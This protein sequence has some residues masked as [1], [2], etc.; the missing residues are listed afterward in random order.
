M[1][2]KTVEL[3]NFRQYGK[4]K[5]EFTK[6]KESNCDL[7][8]IVGKMGVGKTNFL[9]ALNWGLYGKGLFSSI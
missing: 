8:V 6:P 4:F 3:S 1:R 2:L 5:I 9:E 7:H